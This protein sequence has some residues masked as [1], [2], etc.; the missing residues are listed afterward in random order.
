MSEIC[1]MYAR[2]RS[3]MMG[4]S[5]ERVLPRRQHT[6]KRSKRSLP[7]TRAPFDIYVDA[8]ACPVKNEVYRVAIRYRA[9]VYLVSNQ[10]LRVPQKPGLDA[11]LI[12]VES[13]AD[14][15]DQWIADQIKAYDLCVTADLPLAARCVDAQAY[16]LSPRGKEWSAD[17]VSEALAR[18]DLMTSLRE[19]DWGGLELPTGGPPPMTDRDRSAFLNTMD[20]V[21]QRALKAPRP[22]RSTLS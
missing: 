17:T 3:K 8:D 6:L 19:Q 13:G 1:G 21:V 7:L 15:A 10:S 11:K 14:V 16:V 18:R 2:F 20:R 22:D 9:R 4:E 5:K 12:L